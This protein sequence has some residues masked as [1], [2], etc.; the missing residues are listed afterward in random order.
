[1]LA[2]VEIDDEQL[3]QIAFKI[4]NEALFANVLL[5][6]FTVPQLRALRNHA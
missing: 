4:D 6:N 3:I 5:D 2:N 1:M